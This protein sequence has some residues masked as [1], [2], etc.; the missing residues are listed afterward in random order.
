M[1]RLPESQIAENRNLE[2][3][4]RSRDNQIAAG[5]QRDLIEAGLNWPA[6]WRSRLWGLW[7]RWL[8]RGSAG[9]RRR[10]P[11]GVAVQRMGS[12]RRHGLCPACRF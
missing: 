4:V 6:G 3:S 7:W 9:E 11:D 2:G 5:T 1:T 10:S 8:V 12:G